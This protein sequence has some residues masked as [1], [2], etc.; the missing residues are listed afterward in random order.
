MI[1]AGG[2]FHFKKDHPAY[3]IKAQDYATK[4]LFA[5]ATDNRLLNDFFLYVLEDF[6][7]CQSLDR[8]Q[9]TSAEPEFVQ[10]IAER[11][12]PAI[13]ATATCEGIPET[14]AFSRQLIAY[15]AAQLPAAPF[16]RAN[17]RRVTG[18]CDDQYTSTLETLQET[19]DEK[20]K[21]Y[22]TRKT[23]AWFRRWGRPRTS[24]KAPA[25]SD[26]SPSPTG[27]TQTPKRRPAPVAS[28]DEETGGDNEAMAAAMPSSTQPTPQA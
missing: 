3:S 17:D 24:D 28:D 26:A 16:Y 27:A 6:Y 14:R 22:L 13:P 10:E 19:D 23:Q 25:A 1:S 8:L 2:L 5:A 4:P 20:F 21:D 9:F 7:T 15:I 12:Y 11:L 18:I